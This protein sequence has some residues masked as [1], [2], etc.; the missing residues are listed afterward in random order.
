[1]WWDMG[2]LILFALGIWSRTKHSETIDSLKCGVILWSHGLRFHFVFVPFSRALIVTLFTVVCIHG[3]LC[4][5]QVETS[6]SLRLNRTYSSFYFGIRQENK[7][8]IYC[9]FSHK[10]NFHGNFCN[11]ENWYCQYCSN[12]KLFELLVIPFFNHFY[13]IRNGKRAGDIN[14]WSILFRDPECHLRDK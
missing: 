10:I 5:P 2:K 14:I 6:G 11:V 4:M 12:T 7:S 9:I 13:L 3:M 8:Y 1:M